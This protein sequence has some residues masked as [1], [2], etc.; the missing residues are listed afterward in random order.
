MP[1][2]RQHVMLRLDVPRANYQVGVLAATNSINRH[3]SYF[4]ALCEA[5]REAFRESL[6]P[7]RVR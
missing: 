5:L 6:A 7:I 4:G 3:H 1:R 2:T